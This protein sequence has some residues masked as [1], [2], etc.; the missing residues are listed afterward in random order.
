MAVT[1][2]FSGIGSPGNF[3][4]VQGIADAGS[5]RI[6]WG[7][8]TA[9]TGDSP[10]NQSHLYAADGVYTI[11]VIELATGLSEKMHAHFFSG[12]TV[13]VTVAAGGVDD[14]IGGGSGN[15]LFYGGG[16]DDWLF[17]GF[18]A[19]TAF[20]GAGDDFIGGGGA[21]DPNGDVFF[22]EAGSDLLVGDAGDDYLDGGEDGDS[23]YGDAGNDTLYGRDGDDN[24]HGGDGDDY[25]NGGSG[26]DFMTGGAGKD[27]LVTGDDGVVD[28]FVFEAI[29]DGRDTIK[30]F[31]VAEDKI[32]LNFI[33]GGVGP[34]LASGA[35]PAPADGGV[36]LLYDTGNG[37]LSVDLDGTGA[38]EA[39]AIATLKGV[40]AITIDDFLFGAGA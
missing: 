5:V 8:G 15:D 33:D 37:R 21:D 18:G 31:V 14:L 3:L 10:F 36:W 2:S 25:L 12:D 38:G 16:G 30:G 20:G 9:D 39:V 13:G 6:R 34:Q 17:P 29:D 35:A 23:L 27:T 26:V 4:S 22:G 40:P 28:F 19:D 32:A 24:L 11:R 7:D 1:A